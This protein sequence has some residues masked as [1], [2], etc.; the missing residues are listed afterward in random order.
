[1][2]TVVGFLIAAAVGIHCSAPTVSTETSAPELAGTEAPAPSPGRGG[3]P[4]S[5]DGASPVGQPKAPAHLERRDVDFSAFIRDA[6]NAHVT[7]TIVDV[8]TGA[9]YATGTFLSEVEIGGTPVKSKGDKDVFLLKVDATG[10]V[11]WVRAVGSAYAESEPR[12]TLQ[13]SEVNVIGMTDGAM[14]CGSGPLATWSSATFFFCVFGSKDGTSL[15][16]GVFPTG[17]P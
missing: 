11:E 4:K 17:A 14:D 2:R 15:S 16:G 1:M 8:A 6:Q 3:A 5:P 7:S 10:A 9:T 12:V 13:G